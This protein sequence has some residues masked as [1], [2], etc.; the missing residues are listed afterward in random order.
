MTTAFAIQKHVRNR[1]S[2]LRFSR[3]VLG[4]FWGGGY[5][6]KSRVKRVRLRKVVFLEYHDKGTLLGNNVS[7]IFF[8]VQLAIVLFPKYRNTE[9]ALSR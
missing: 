5:F 1:H 6:F 2:I 9:T 8:E 7:A 4:V 3:G